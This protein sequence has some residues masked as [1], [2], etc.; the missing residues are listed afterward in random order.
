MEISSGPTTVFF[1]IEKSKWIKH[2]S[3]NKAIFRMQQVYLYYACIYRALFL[4]I[5]EKIAAAT[6]LLDNC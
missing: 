1:V 6:D 5:Y 2:S 4:L 3:A